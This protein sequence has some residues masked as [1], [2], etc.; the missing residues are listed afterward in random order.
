MEGL[1]SQSRP[2]RTLR[3]GCASGCSRLLQLLPFPPHRQQTSSGDDC[4]L[5]HV[6]SSCEMAAGEHTVGQW[7][8]VCQGWKWTATELHLPKRGQMR[9]QVGPPGPGCARRTLSHSTPVMWPSPSISAHHSC[10][11]PIVSYALLKACRVNTC[12]LW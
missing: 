12:I 2:K 10:Y 9:V 4:T 6:Q 11:G 5:W 1:D 3:L 8:V 7:H